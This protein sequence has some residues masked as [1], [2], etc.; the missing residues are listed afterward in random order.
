[1][2]HQKKTLLTE[3]SRRVPTIEKDGTVYMAINSSAS[4]DDYESI[5]IQNQL[6]A[7]NNHVV[8]TANQLYISKSKI[9]DMLNESKGSG[10]SPKK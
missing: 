1:M 8:N 9:Y 4:L 10:Q 5:I 3:S 6:N 2:S 7:N